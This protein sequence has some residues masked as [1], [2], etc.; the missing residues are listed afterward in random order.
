L[1]LAFGHS[2]K[3]LERS[4]YVG[5]DAIEAARFFTKEAFDKVNGYNELLISGEDW[6]LSDRVEE[7]GKIERI[8]EYIYHNEGHTSLTSTL[9]KKYYY[10]KKAKAYLN[11]QNTAV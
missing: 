5:V 1:V 7:Q 6:D 10:A 3:K 8:N 9:K 11:Q 4:F 2:A